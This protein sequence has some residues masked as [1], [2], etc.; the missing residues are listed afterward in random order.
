M[1]LHVANHNFKI[2]IPEFEGSKPQI[3]LN[4]LVIA[5]LFASYDSSRKKYFQVEKHQVNLVSEKKF[6]RNSDDLSNICHNLLQT[7]SW[8]RNSTDYI[9]I[10]N[11]TLKGLKEYEKFLNEPPV[12]LKETIGKI[13]QLFKVRELIFNNNGSPQF[14]AAAT[15]WLKE[16]INLSSELKET[17]HDDKIQNLQACIDNKELAFSTVVLMQKTTKQKIKEDF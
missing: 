12:I 11:Y 16:K 8:F 14:L 1:T 2:K 5:G 17:Y 10:L 7:T 9:Y 6:K 15:S 4:G 3:E 13:E